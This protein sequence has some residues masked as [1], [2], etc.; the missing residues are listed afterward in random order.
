M[1][2]GLGGSPYW[3]PG[4]FTGPGGYDYGGTPWGGQMLEASPETAYYRYGRGLGVADDGSAFSRWFRQQYPQAQLGYQ[5][6]T[7]SDPLNAN[8]Q[9]YLGT[10]G[11]FDD[12]LRRFRAQA[13][14]LRGLDPASRGGN[15]V[16]WIG[17]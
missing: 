6:Y 5:A 12:W 2:L 16:R 1:P 15:P 17:R 10:L 9:G 14:Q 4:Q 8:I 13:P 7:V 11:G 3:S